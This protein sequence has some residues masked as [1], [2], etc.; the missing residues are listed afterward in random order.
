MLSKNSIALAAAVAVAIVSIWPAHAQTATS[1]TTAPAPNP[2][3]T[4]HETIQ[5]TAT[6]VPEDVLS[7]PASVT[8]ISGEDLAARGVT[9]LASAL[10]LVAGVNVAPGGDGG[11]AGSVPEIWGLREFDAFLL[12]VDGVPWGGAFNPALPSLDLTNVER[13]EVLRGSAPVM[14]GATS[15]VGVIHVIHHAAGDATGSATVGVRNHGGGIAAVV[16]PLGAHGGLQ[17]SLTVNGERTGYDDDRAGYDRGHLLYRATAD[18][19]AGAFRF[20]ADVAVTRQD[21]SSPHPREGGSLSSRVPLDANH[22]PKDAHID[23]D[24][25]HLVAGLD[26]RLGDNPWTSTLAVTHTRRDLTRG[27]LGELDDGA[28]PNAAGFRQDQTQTD[29]YFDSHLVFHP[30]A[31]LQLIAGVDLLYGKGK[32]A[33]DNVDY[34]VNLDG[35][36]AQDSHAVPVQESPSLEDERTFAGLYLQGEWTPAPR[37]RVEAGLRLNQTHEDQEGEVE[38]EDGE[39]RSSSSASNTKA[40]GVVGVSLLAWDG[41]GGDAVWAYAD[42]RNTFK[43][44]AIDFGPEAEGGILDP[45]TATSVEAGLKGAHG[46]GRW[47]WQASVFR[48]DFDNLV[49]AAEVDGLPV[50]INAGQERF[51]GFELEGEA[52][53]GHDLRLAGAYSNHDARFRDFVQDFDGVPTQLRGHRLEMSANDLASLGL[54]YSPATGIG[55]HLVWNY[56]GDR[57]LNKRNTALAGAYD[58]VGAGISYQTSRTTVRLDGWNLGDARDP[59][60]ESELGDSQYYRL[61][62][63]SYQLSGTWRF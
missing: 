43:P 19:A 13:I 30:T 38:S 27:F 41:G 47:R 48:L 3:L 11:P 10:S 56:V 33:G 24:R 18:T 12:V 50:L 35:S 62:G 22:Q 61:P 45:E 23:E 51:D 34:H 60:A 54:L 6:R 29:L 37:W 44:A 5:V 14:Y 21:P 57:F 42:Y 32:S 53:L 15:F 8:V 40:S 7:T 59:V 49:T 1:A 20:D 58:T 4:H 16:V 36:G 17:Q 39:E 25:F 55:G 52:E 26:R 31:T 63:R 2:A 46:G 9:D 28:D